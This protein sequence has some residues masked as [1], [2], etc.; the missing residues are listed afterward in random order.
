VE[1]AELGQVLLHL[2]L[3]ELIQQGVDL[4]LMCDLLRENAHGLRAEGAKVGIVGDVE[5]ALAVLRG[6]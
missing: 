3:L 6:Q 5:E 2:A 4:L 1:R